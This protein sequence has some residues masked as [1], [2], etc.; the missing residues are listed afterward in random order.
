MIGNVPLSLN[1]N[2]NGGTVTGVA[3]TAPSTQPSREI[4]TTVQPTNNQNVTTT[5]IGWLDNHIRNYIKSSS[6]ITE[7]NQ[8]S[9]SFSE[10]EVQCVEV[11]GMDCS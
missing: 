3:Y 1:F 7:I 2:V 8:E 5:G 9:I 6:V 10:P 11:T 4:L